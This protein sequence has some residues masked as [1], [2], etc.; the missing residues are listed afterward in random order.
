MGTGN[1]LQKFASARNS[2]AFKTTRIFV[3]SLTLAD[4]VP[5]TVRK[6]IS[7]VNVGSFNALTAPRE[8][9]CQTVEI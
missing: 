4:Y 3:N 1:P 2:H 7:R 5:H 9:L 8:N 6:H